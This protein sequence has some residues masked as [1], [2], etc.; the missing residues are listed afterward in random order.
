MGRWMGRWRLSDKKLLTTVF[1]NRHALRGEKMSGKQIYLSR[2]GN[3]GL[4]NCNDFAPLLSYPIFSTRQKNKTTNA[5]R[6][7]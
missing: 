4:I 2:K 6:I 7:E 5:S 1:G 3:R